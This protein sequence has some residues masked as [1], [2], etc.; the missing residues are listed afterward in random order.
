M[1]TLDNNGKKLI[2]KRFKTDN[3]KDTSKKYDESF[4]PKAAEILARLGLKNYQIYILFNISEPTGVSWY[5]RIPEF[6]LAIKNGRANKVEF[7]FS[8]TGG[9]I[10]LRERLPELIIE[11]EELKKQN[12][13][14]KDELNI[15]YRP[16][17]PEH[18]KQ[19]RLLND[20]L[21][22]QKP[23]KNIIEHIKPE[24]PKGLH[25]Q[26][27]NNDMTPRELERFLLTENREERKER[28]NQKHYYNMADY[29]NSETEEDRKERYR[30]GLLTE[31]ERADM[32]PGW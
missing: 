26:F 16:A 4:H 21:E 19:M 18:E 31:E 27:I 1:K 24:A 13:R 29:F 28:W 14:L 15:K 17:N 5:R 10:E 3:M 23:I 12:E 32:T 2:D 9:E 7:N 30:K 8:P 25:V 20:M 11:I 6:N 22:K